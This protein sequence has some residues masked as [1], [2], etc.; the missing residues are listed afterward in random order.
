MLLKKV[1][2]VASAFDLI[3]PGYI[4][5]FEETKKH[6]DFLLVGLHNDPS[7]ERP[8]KR[9]PLLTLQERKATLNSIK[10]IDRVIEYDTESDLYSILK[11]EKIDVRFLGD[12]YVGRDDFTGADLN[13]EFVYIKR[14]HG[15]SYR[16][17]I[18]MIKKEN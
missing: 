2:F 16:K 14:D 9:K 7:M 5:M 11:N 6:C 1:G 18:D 4:Y 8:K 13:M 3:H 10:Y 17:L 12:D 15:W